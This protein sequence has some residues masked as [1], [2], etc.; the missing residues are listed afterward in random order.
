MSEIRV[1]S[2][3]FKFEKGFG[4]VKVDEEDYQFKEDP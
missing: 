2:T 3:Y 1:V 4:W